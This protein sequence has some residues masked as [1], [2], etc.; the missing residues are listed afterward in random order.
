VIPRH[1][2]KLGTTQGDAYT[3]DELLL[4]WWRWIIFNKLLNQIFQIINLVL[5]VTNHLRIVLNMVHEPIG[6]RIPALGIVSPSFFTLGAFYP[7]IVRTIYIP[8][9]G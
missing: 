6:K 8:A 2:P 9:R 1:S 4:G 3:D 7:C 5:E